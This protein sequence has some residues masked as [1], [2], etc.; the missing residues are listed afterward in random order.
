[1]LYYDHL[2]WLLP[3]ETGDYGMTGQTVLRIV[4]EELRRNPEVVIILH[5][6]AA[7]TIVKEE[8]TRTEHATP[9]IVQVIMVDVKT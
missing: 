5:L 3:L 2:Q 6:K 1:M 7:E 4:E 8:V 9:S